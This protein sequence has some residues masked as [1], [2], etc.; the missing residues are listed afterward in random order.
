MIR[1][2][3]GA[4]ILTAAL[5]LT[6]CS[7]STTL[8]DLNLLDD[9]IVGVDVQGDTVV[10]NPD[11]VDRDVTGTDTIG[12]DTNVSDTTTQDTTVQDTTAEDTAGQDTATTDTVTTTC[13][14]ACTYGTDGLWCLEDGTTICYCGEDGTWVPYVCADICAGSYMVGDQCAEVDGEVNCQ[15]EY[16]CTKTDLVSSQCAD[17]SYTPCTCSA[18]NPCSFIG[19][20]FCDADCAT[21]Y[22]EDHLD[23]PDDCTCSGACDAE[24]FTGFC[25]AG[26]A[27]ACTESVRTVQNCTDYCATMG[28]TPDA[29]E[30]CYTYGGAAYC[31]CSN[32][33]CDDETKVATQCTELLY[34]PCTCAAA[35]VCG[36]AADGACDSTYCNS[37]YPDQTNFTETT[38]CAE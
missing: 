26:N 1:R 4:A 5:A 27:C 10:V 17:Y 34:T 38:D 30:P 15:C 29:E 28:A 22:P 8:T 20:G 37:L 12:T 25:D 7:S 24:N 16:D 18:S 31:Q 36:W 13:S 19:D 14:G 32:F 2:I 9:V 23:D 21:Y 3:F 33:T 11:A 35:D 6:A